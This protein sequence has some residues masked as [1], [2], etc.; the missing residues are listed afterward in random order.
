MGGMTWGVGAGPVLPPSRRRPVLVLAGIAVAS[1]IG[2]VFTVNAATTSARSSDRRAPAT[3]TTTSTTI[4][5]F[6]DDGPL[7]AVH[8]YRGGLISLAPPPAGTRPRVTASDAFSNRGGYAWR[9]EP[10][11]PHVLLAVATVSDYGRGAGDGD[12]TVSPF[13][14]HR[15][16]W[17]VEYSDVSAASFP[18]AGRG[19][20]GGTGMASTTRAP[21]PTTS[22]APDARTFTVLSFVDAAT[23]THLGT[24]GFANHPGT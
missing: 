10:A 8:I 22:T 15:L 12:G 18:R 7:T 20:L 11:P 21:G 9:E 13:I 2:V 1:A 6:V 17:V 24:S 14:D 16:V 23:G 4:P 19:V 3:S 5:M